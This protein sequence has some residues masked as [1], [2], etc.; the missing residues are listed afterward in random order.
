MSLGFKQNYMFFFFQTF[1]AAS[2]NRSCIDESNSNTNSTSN[3]D[4]LEQGPNSQGDQITSPGVSTLVAG[5]TT[6]SRRSSR[7]HFTQDIGN[8]RNGVENNS[9]SDIVVTSVKGKMKQSKKIPY[10]LWFGIAKI[11]GIR[12]N[13]K[14]KPMLSWVL[15][16]ITVL[17]A[18]GK[19]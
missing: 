4:I 6:D 11:L 14:D 5:S 3:F 19:F 18:T 15:H 8:R 12:L 7:T 10:W 13:Y 17:S 2:I 9:E 16:L 1:Q